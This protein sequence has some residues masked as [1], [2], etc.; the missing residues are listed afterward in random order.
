MFIAFPIT[1]FREFDLSNACK[2]SLS[3]GNRRS[4]HRVGAGTAQF[5][6]KSSDL[7]RAG[8][9]A[10]PSSGL[11]HS[12]DCCAFWKSNRIWIEFRNSDGEV[13]SVFVCCD[14]L[15]FLIWNKYSTILDP[16]DFVVPGADYDED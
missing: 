15:L 2:R 8:L 9:M 12:P 13:L 14:I 16:A 7:C 4:P 3:T 1:L 11:P 5:I 10:G 6:Q